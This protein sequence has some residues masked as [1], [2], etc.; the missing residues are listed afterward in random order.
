MRVAVMGAGGIGSYFGAMLAR[1]GVETTLICRG[2]HLE[3]IR[4]NG[5]RV[6]T[7]G[8]EFTIDT[9]SATD[10]PAAVAPAD[11]IIQS[12]KLYDLASSCG[13]MLPMIG[14]HTMVVPIQNGITAH[15]EIGAVVGAERV[16]GGMTFVN[17]MVESPGAVHR[18]SE[19]NL[20]V[21]GELDGRISARVAAFRDLCL[22]A[23]IEARASENIL[24]ELWRKFIP[25]AS[26]S[27]IACLSRQP[28]GPMRDDPL[29]RALFVRAMSEV[30]A[31]GEASGI[32]F[33][34]DIV[35]RMLALAQRFND[36]AK[37]SMLED[38]EAGKPLELDWLSGTVS[39]EARRLGVAAPFHDLAYACLKP[40]AGGSRK[41]S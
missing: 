35:E 23:G 7:P 26:L 27:A 34:P 19:A 17:A 21:F 29:L 39:R 30:V 8:G 14:P 38:L 3:A 11:V 13:Q 4:A 32:A 6:A 37:V 16:V 5:L 41:L 1:S 18:R 20:L 15:Q 9:I 22:A 40:L 25:L 2:A 28:M 24:K 33:E 36:E 31:L 12:V 10:D